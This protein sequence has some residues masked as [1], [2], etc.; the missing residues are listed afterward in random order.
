MLAHGT[1]FS[2]M[3]YFYFLFYL[4]FCI[5]MQATFCTCH[6]AGKPNT[7]YWRKSIMKLLITSFLPTRYMFH[8]KIFLRHCLITLSSF[9]QW[10]KLNSEQAG[11]TNKSY[12][13]FQARSQNC[14]KWLIASSILLV[15][16]P[17]C[18]SAWN[19]SALTGRI[20]MRFNI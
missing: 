19:K 20:F 12:D 9:S 2:A 5:F 18:P 6:Y 1:L 14:E 7:L 10:C 8:S 3:I 16:P 4:F 11:S 15:C 17:I 13:Y